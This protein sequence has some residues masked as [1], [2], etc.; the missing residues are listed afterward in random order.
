MRDSLPRKNISIFL[1]FFLLGIFGCGGVRG[2]LPAPPDLITRIE[3]K[4]IYDGDIPKKLVKQLKWASITS[5]WAIPYIFMNVALHFESV[6]DEL[7][8]VHFFDRAIIEVRKRKDAYGEGT[9]TNQKVLALC[10]FGKMQN[11]YNIIKEA[12]KNWSN[13]PLNAFVFQSYGH[14]YL[15]SGDYGKA[16]KYFRQSFDSNR[17]FH[18]NFNLLMLRRDSEMEYGMAVI[19]ADYIPAI[20]PKLSLLDFDEAFYKEIRKN[21]DE[22]ISHLNQV[23]ILNKEIRKTKIN[24]FIP[25]IVFQTF[26]SNVYNFLGLAYGIKGQFPEAI[27]NF[28]TSAKL[29]G[30]IYFPIGEINSMFFRNQV[31]LLGKNITEGQKTARQ[32]NELADQ[33]H[34]PFYQIWA[35]LILSRYYSKY[36][37]TSQAIDLLKNAITVMETQHAELAI[38]MFKEN[39]L[40]NRQEIYEEL[41]E[42]LIEEGDNNG[43][44]ETAESAKSWAMVDLL[45]GEDIGKNST[46]AELIRQNGSYINEISDGYRKIMVSAGSDFDFKKTLDKIE[47]AE[48][49]RRD[50]IAKIKAQNEELYSMVSVE[51]PETESLRQL[52]DRNTTLFSYYVT[53]KVLYIWAI[54]KDRVH[55]ERIKITKGEVAKLV[56]SFIAAIAA[57]DKKQTDSLSEKVYDIFLRPVIPF[58]SGDRIGFIPHGSLYYLP[59]A[60]MSYKGQ[61]LVDGFSIFYLPNAGVLKYVLKKQMTQEMKVLAFA[62]PDLGDKQ[63]EMPFAEAEVESIKKNI[64]RITMFFYAGSPSVVTTIWDI[65]DK[66]KANFMDIFYSNLKKDESIADSLRTTQNEMIKL[67]Y[68]PFDWAAFI[69]TGKY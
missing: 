48:N 9:I 60:A 32:L 42:L 21:V 6:G 45:A 53:D 18:D 22:G 17:S 29:S 62:N 68:P 55:L 51:P 67:G 37:N 40:F 16:L 15:M 43:A 63:L 8:A 65:E 24:R 31:Q 23:M 5:D 13:A 10:N 57:R 28:N 38:D 34:L 52:L 14:Y 64:S 61:Y 47:K 54:N 12:E 3:I 27:N 44:L 20:S 56:S 58:V 1:I 46:E 39:V 33:Y 19:L 50:V 69:V 25:D 11:A 35:K 59:F 7:R 36:G 4:D 30:K 41:I 2:Y 26:E 66:S 49:A